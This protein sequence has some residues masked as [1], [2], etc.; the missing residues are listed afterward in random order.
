MAFAESVSSLKEAEVAR[1]LSAA[2]HF[3]GIGGGVGFV[4]Y[5]MLPGPA[6]EVRL[7]G[8]SVSLAPR[9]V[10]LLNI[11]RQRFQ[12]RPCCSVGTRTK[13]IARGVGRDTNA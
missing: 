6:A 1:P 8:K 4:N 10:P 7:E 12:R 5:G 11:Q 9:S 13:R 3:A 2:F